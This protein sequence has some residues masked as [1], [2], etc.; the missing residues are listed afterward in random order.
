MLLKLSYLNRNSLKIAF[1]LLLLFFFESIIIITAIILLIRAEWVILLSFFFL[2]FDICHGYF[3]RIAQEI[4]FFLLYFILLLKW[5]S[6]NKFRFFN[7]KINLFVIFKL[8]VYSRC[9]YGYYTASKVRNSQNLKWNKKYLSHV[10]CITMAIIYIF[11]THVNQH[12][13]I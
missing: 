11:N 13:F 5:V 3:Y 10:S 1:F 4:V 8:L 9:E 12:R 2:I 6:D 7:K